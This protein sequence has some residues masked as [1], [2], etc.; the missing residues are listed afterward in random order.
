MFTNPVT[1]T[2]QG[3]RIVHAR[4]AARKNGMAK[5]LRDHDL[6]H[7]HVAWLLTDRIALLAVSRRLGREL[8]GITA[9]IHGHLLPE[10]EDAIRMVPVNRRAAPSPTRAA[11]V[12]RRLWTR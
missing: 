11:R 5:T 6:R 7:T 1:G 9:D 2:W 4:T 12:R 8:I 10:G 3:R